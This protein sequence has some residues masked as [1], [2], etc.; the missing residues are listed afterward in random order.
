LRGLH[1]AHAW[2]PAT[3]DPLLLTTE[4]ARAGLAALLAGP[5]PRARVTAYQELPPSVQL[6]PLGRIGW[7]R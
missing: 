5:W 6:R 4:G 2:T 3:R 7:L 1:A